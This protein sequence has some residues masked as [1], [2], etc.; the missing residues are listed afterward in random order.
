MPKDRNPARYDGELIRLF[1]TAFEHGCHHGD[2]TDGVG[3]LGSM[4]YTLE[5][6]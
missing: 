2:D 1:F 4:E 5:T 6:D 3:F